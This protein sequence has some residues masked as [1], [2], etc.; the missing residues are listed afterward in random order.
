MRGLLRRES[1]RPL[2]RGEKAGEEREIRRAPVLALS[3]VV[4]ALL[5]TAC[6]S[7]SGIGRSVQAIPSA[8][9][10]VQ[11]NVI[12]GDVLAPG[13]P[14]PFYLFEQA[15][16]PTDIQEASLSLVKQVPRQ[17]NLHVVALKSTQDTAAVIVLEVS[18]HGRWGELMIPAE[19]RI[20][21]AF[22]AD[23]SLGKWLILL[24]DVDIRGEPDPIPLTAYRWTR[25]D[26][27][28]YERCGIPQSEIDS[29]TQAFFLVA[30]TVIVSTGFR[31]VQQ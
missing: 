6:F 27:Q 28:T 4:L 13:P 20:I 2:R 15:T 12:L 3:L 14:Y 5:S 26:V 7:G 22:A 10:A 25:D 30:K 31:G 29:C 21:R 23:R 24:S 1:C 16:P 19:R 9:E 18:N 8:S 17:K 11:A